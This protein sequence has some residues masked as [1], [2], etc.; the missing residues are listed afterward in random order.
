MRFLAVIGALAILVA[1]GAGIF[2]FGGFYSVAENEDNPAFVDWA[3]ATSA[4]PRSSGHATETPPANLD[5]PATVK[6]GAQRLRDHRLRQ[7]SR[8][9]AGQQLGQVVRRAEAGSGR[10]QGDGERADAAPQ[11]FWVDQE[12]HQVHRHAELRPGR[13]VRPG[14]LVDRRLHQEACRRCRTTTTRPGR[15]RPERA[16]AAHPS[17]STRCGISGASAGGIG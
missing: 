4:A 13:G 14:H 16:R 8:R 2:F 10:S 6:A 1:I 3:L 7:L 11:L 15:R 17:K 12:R 9:A 5:D